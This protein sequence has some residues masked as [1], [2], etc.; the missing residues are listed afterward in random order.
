MQVWLL[1]ISHVVSLLLV[2]VIGLCDSSVIKLSAGRGG[3][4]WVP[5]GTAHGRELQIRWSGEFCWV[6]P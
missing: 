2:R 1:N 6:F 4:S 3:E 5:L